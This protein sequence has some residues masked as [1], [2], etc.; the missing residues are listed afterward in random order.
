MGKM[1]SNKSRNKEASPDEV[2]ERKSSHAHEQVSVKE[3]DLASD[4]LVGDM[5]DALLDR[6]RNMKKPWQQMTESEQQDVVLHMSDIAKHLTRRA[7][8][9]IAQN[10]R[11]TINATVESV[12]V[13]GGLKVVVKAHKTRETVAALS[14]AEGHPILLVAASSLAFDGERG[15][16]ET[17]PDQGDLEEIAA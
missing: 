2:E 7:V 10:G 13:K 4:T 9:L 11:E 15:P 14:D 1:K 8:E 3:V 17:D 6:I 5:R 12:T 16:A